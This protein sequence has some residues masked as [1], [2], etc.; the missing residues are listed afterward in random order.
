MARKR[1]IGHIVPP[2]GIPNSIVRVKTIFWKLRRELP[3]VWRNNIASRLTGDTHVD[4]VFAAQGR[5]LLQ[6]GKLENGIFPI[7]TRMQSDNEIADGI[8]E[9]R[10][11]WNANNID[12]KRKSKAKIASVFK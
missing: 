11:A 5:K 7:Y 9:A 6:V 2:S 3:V 1:Q 12:Q 4:I 8:N 10:V